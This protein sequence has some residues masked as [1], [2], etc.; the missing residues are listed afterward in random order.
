MFNYRNR[1]VAGSVGDK[2]DFK[3]GIVLVEDGAKVLCQS[4]IQSATRGKDTNEGREMRD[5]AS[6]FRADIAP[7]SHSAAK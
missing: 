3:R 5:F 4:L 7:K 6:E 1:R 2:D